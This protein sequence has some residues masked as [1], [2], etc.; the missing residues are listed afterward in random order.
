MFNSIHSLEDVDHLIAE[1]IECVKNQEAE[2]LADEKFGSID[3][4]NNVDYINH[5]KYELIDSVKDEKDLSNRDLVEKDTCVM[6]D[7]QEDFNFIDD[8]DVPN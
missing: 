3:S 1:R 2:N 6:Q 5:V 7:S 8:D 4:Q